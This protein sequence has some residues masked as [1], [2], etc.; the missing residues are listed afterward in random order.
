M[1]WKV[2][3]MMEE[4]S[5]GGEGLGDVCKHNRHALIDTSMIRA[6]IS[7]FSVRMG[8]WIIS[9]VSSQPRLANLAR[10]WRHL[11]RGASF[12]GRLAPEG[13]DF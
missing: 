11:L 4:V 13:G 3:L 5:R 7:P 12:E 9:V 6:A 8:R 1:V 2:N 10:S